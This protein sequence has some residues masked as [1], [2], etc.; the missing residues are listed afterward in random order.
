MIDSKFSVAF[1]ANRL[2]IPQVNKGCRATGGSFATKTGQLS[3][4]PGK[5]GAAFELVGS[6]SHLFKGG[7]L[8]K[9]EALYLPDGF[10]RLGACL[11]PF[12]GLGAVGSDYGAERP[13][14]RAVKTMGA[15]SV[16]GRR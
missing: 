6:S 4:Q 7:G 2:P 13:L 16:I 8:V 15:Q 10:A 9:P 5:H 11:S 3:R 12:A 14:P 1:I